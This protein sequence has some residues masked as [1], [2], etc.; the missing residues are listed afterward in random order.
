MVDGLLH[1]PASPANGTAA[2]AVRLRHMCILL[3]HDRTVAASG[4]SPMLRNRRCERQVQQ[5]R[6]RHHAKAS[7][8]PAEL[9]PT[10]SD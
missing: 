1:I 7:P 9:P 4:A 2:L 8:S 3:F 10:P 5:Q 6:L